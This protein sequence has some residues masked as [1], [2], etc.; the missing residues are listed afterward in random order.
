MD[1]NENKVIINRM[2]IHSIP[3][4]CLRDIE[5]KGPIGIL[6]G[7]ATGKTST[8]EYILRSNSNS[9]INDKAIVVGCT[10]S[11]EAYVR[12]TKIVP[13]QNVYKGFKEN[14]V[15]KDLTRR[16]SGA[17]LDKTAFIDCEI[18]HCLPSTLSRLIYPAFGWTIIIASSSLK[19]FPNKRGCWKY[20]VIFPQFYSSLK[21]WQQESPDFEEN[22]RAFYWLYMAGNGFHISQDVFV[23]L[24]L[25]M[26]TL[27][28]DFSSSNYGVFVLDNENMNRNIKP[29]RR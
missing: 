15:P 11:Q 16:G 12:Y 8:V 4:I 23:E 1:K 17:N 2:D 25:N 22:Y 13:S 3:S 7:H 21:Q 26:K 18:D 6:G 20:F 24:L 5:W 14:L 10:D 29:A 9:N 19:V 27:V 28:V